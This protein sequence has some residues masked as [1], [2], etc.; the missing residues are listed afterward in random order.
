MDNLHEFSKQLIDG[1]RSLCVEM[2]KS[3]ILNNE[4]INKLKEICETPDI[5][6]DDDLKTRLD[7]ELFIVIKY[8]RKFN[9][10]TQICDKINNMKLILKNNTNFDLFDL[11][12][13]NSEIE[14]SI[15]LFNASNIIN[16]ELL[17][18]F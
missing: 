10:F 16:L 15:K 1:F 14:Q 7:P 4:F 13:L 5:P 11:S 6:S 2:D 18:T 8:N 9:D 3:I 12:A 17:S